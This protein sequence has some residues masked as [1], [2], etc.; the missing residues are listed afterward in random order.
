M[1]RNTSEGRLWKMERCD[2]QDRSTEEQSWIIPHPT[3]SAWR[4]SREFHK[5]SLVKHIVGY[6]PRKNN[7]NDAK[8]MDTFLKRVPE[9]DLVMTNLGPDKDYL[10]VQAPLLDYL[11]VETEGSTGWKYPKLQELRGSTEKRTNIFCIGRR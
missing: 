10:L 8:C 9:S 7:Q 4:D 3:R 5:V 2:R 6:K 1:E 11:T